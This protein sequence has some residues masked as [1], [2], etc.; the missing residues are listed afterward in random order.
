MNIIKQIR[1]K[2]FNLVREGDHFRLCE[3]KNDKK[4]FG[5]PTKSKGRKGQASP[6]KK[7]KRK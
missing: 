1:H 6:W 7:T 3:M 4:N 5:R 2:T